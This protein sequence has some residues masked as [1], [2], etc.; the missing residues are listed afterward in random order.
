MDK[1]EIARK[2]FTLDIQKLRRSQTDA[3]FRR[4]L[5]AHFNHIETTVVRPRGL[6]TK[7]GHRKLNSDD[8]QKVVA[9]YNN[10][11]YSIGEICRVMNISKP[12][13]YRYVKNV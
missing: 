8:I 11:T 9:M 6:G 5:L 13:L 12:T 1:K 2:I 3:A 4:I 10:P 7:T